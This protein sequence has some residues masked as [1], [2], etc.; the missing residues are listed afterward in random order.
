MSEISKVFAVEA[1]CTIGGLLKKAPLA[2][3]ENRILLMHAL[4]LTRIQLITQDERSIDAQ[5]A[6]QLSIL[7]DRRLRGEPVAYII[8]HREFYGLQLEVTPDVLIPR[9]ETELLVDLALQHLPLNGQQ[10]LSVLDLGTGSGAIA[11]AIAHSRPD[12]AVTALDVSDAALAVAARNAARHLP[13]EHGQFRL[14]HSNWY[15]ALGDEQFDVI[16]ANPPYIVAGDQHLAQGDL[17]FEPQ[18]ALTDHADGL[19]ALR[20]IID[21]AGRYLK[22]GGWLLMEH[23]YDQAP[24]VRALLQAQQYKTVQ[25]WDDIA[26]IERVS[27]GKRNAAG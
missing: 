19:S 3:L 23:G 11:I 20:N 14:L 17:R 15:S 24:A 9:P 6:Q 5:Q 22:N 10:Q 27:G 25:S 1:G 7:F 21:G 18:D 13:S 12:L 8:G 16:V 4:Q 2:P 26:A